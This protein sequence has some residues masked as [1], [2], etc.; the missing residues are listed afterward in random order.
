MSFKTLF[1]LLLG[2]STANFSHAGDF[3]QYEELQA[4]IASLEREAIYPRGELNTVFSQVKR[5]NKALET[6][7]RPAEGTKEWK[8]YRPSFLSN[9]R[10]NRGLDFWDKYHE[11]LEVAEQQFGV[12]PEIILAILG[13]ETKFGGNKGGF[14][15]LD[16]LTTMAFDF[17]RRS[18]F[19]R[20]ELKSYLILCKQQGLNPTEQ[21]G[22]Y[23]GAMGF[24]Q[25]MPSSWRNLGIDFDGDNK[26]DLINNPIDAIGSIGNYFAANGWK[27]D[28][29]IATRA[30]IIGDNYDELINTKE[31]KTLTT[32]A[33]LKAKGLDVKEGSFAE[34]TPVS[35]LRLQGD[36]GAEFWLTFNNFYVITTYNRSHL[37]AMAVFQLSQALKEAKQQLSTAQDA[38]AAAP[39]IAPQPVV[40]TTTIP[41]AP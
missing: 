12:P 20:Q 2:L 22:S 9:E 21:L 23:A 33:E 32:L 13:V 7:M 38:L 40:D 19:F 28:E 34:N 25:F 36:N 10:I 41:P 26:A 39:T 24:P 16:T 15:V 4:L 35:A 30:K 31:L 3:D 8:D 18:T 6:M 29:A 11:A 1:S 17:P 27:K 5:Q 14:K 37:Y